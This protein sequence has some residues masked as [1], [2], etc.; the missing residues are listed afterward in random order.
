MKFK[1]KAV[2]SEYPNNGY[3]FVKTSGYYS[4]TVGTPTLSLSYQLYDEKDKLFGTFYSRD[5]AKEAAKYI[6]NKNANVEEFSV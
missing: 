2:F 6:K 3:T 1:I 5:A 4:Q